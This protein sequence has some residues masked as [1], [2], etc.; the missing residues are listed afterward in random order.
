MQNDNK[1]PEQIAEAT[2]RQYITAPFARDQM[3]P[4]E[5]IAG[6]GL[7]NAQAASIFDMVVDAIETDRRI[8][9]SVPADVLREHDRQVAERAWDEAVEE[10]HALGWL[11]DF[12]KSDALARNPYRT[13]EENNDN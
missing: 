2:V 5:L 13:K 1:T 8:L 11:H 7:S 4:R 6:L 10:T 3:D 9:S 12:A